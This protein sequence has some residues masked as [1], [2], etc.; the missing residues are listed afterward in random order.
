MARPATPDVKITEAL[1]P[2]ASPLGIYDK[3]AS[4]E[5]SPLHGVAT[6]L[7]SLSGDL[8][9]WGAKQ[10]AD[11]KAADIARGELNF[12]RDNAA[13]Y[14]EGVRRG[15]IPI[16][17]SPNVAEGYQRAA[18]L[19]AGVS[20]D[21]TLGNS[22][23]EWGDSTNPDP[24]A[25]ETWFRSNVGKNIPL[26]ASGGFARGLA[27]QLAQLHE[28][29]HNK[30]QAEVTKN[31]ENTALV[32]YGAAMA[33]TV[34]DAAQ[35]AAQDG[36]LIDTDRLGAN[37]AAIR[38]HGKSIGL[39]NAQ[40]D[41]LLL[42]TIQ[43][44]TLTTRDPSLLSLY[45]MPSAAGSKLSDT[46]DGVEAKKKTEDALT[47]LW[48]TQETEARQQQDR[49][50]KLQANQAQQQIIDQL[51]KDPNTPISDEQMAPALKLNG[52]F[53]IDVGEWQKKLREGKVVDDPTALSHLYGDILSGKANRDDIM[54]AWSAGQLQTPEA[55][56][57]AM[58]FLKT[59]QDYSKR[60]D[61]ILSQGT[62]KDTVEAIKK[63]G[64][65]PGM[66]DIFGNAALT[67]QGMQA[68]SDFR[69]G[70][71]KWDMQHPDADPIQRQQFLDTYG[72]KILQG[73]GSGG[74]GA[75]PGVSSYNRPAEAAAVN[76]AVNLM[77]HAQQQPQ[78]PQP[79]APPAPAQQP[80]AP[81]TPQ[82]PQPAAPPW[83][84][85]P[86]M[87]PAIEQKAK[88]LGVPA[89]TIIDSMNRKRQQLLA[90]P[91]AVP[92]TPPQVPEK[93]SDL[94][95]PGAFQMAAINPRAA[96]EAVRNVAQRLGL[97]GA[98]SNPE[99]QA[100]SQETSNAMNS[101]RVMEIKNSS[102]GPMLQQVAQQTGFDPDKLMAIA[103]I[104]SS[105]DHLAG[106]G[107]GKRPLT[108]YKGLFQL[109]ADEWRR[110]GDGGDI[111]DPEANARAA[112]R[113][114]Q[115]KSARFAKEFGREPSATELYMMHQQ[116][117]A[118][119]RSHEQRPDAPAWTNMLRT[120]E[121]RRKGEEWAKRAIWGNVPTDM[122]RHFG[123]VENITS[124]QFLAVW[125]SKLL[126]VGYEQALAM[127]GGGTANG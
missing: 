33:S 113:S 89:S 65:V 66:M 35:D 17:K 56:T 21:S 25:F 63:H 73:F 122:R 87:I 45:D 54:S 49:Q 47:H 46:P 36:T 86:E 75:A 4:P 101:Q 106:S 74:P 48:K 37:L 110:Y 80:A 32:N 55:M 116:G 9:A 124:R 60:P 117:E 120:G 97:G 64:A 43:A 78:A 94:G 96:V 22:F 126:G 111:Y 121:G 19:S 44:K 40:I 1:S 109:N 28:K 125:T 12:Y 27:P 103:S 77:P 71:I 23:S 42:A 7:S 6:A 82:A 99:P 5:P 98:I 8:A 76:D 67:P 20:L 91:P 3:P 84:P 108:P 118:G 104:E 81:Q 51:I 92:A 13:G 30:W 112:V 114:L 100:S 105:G 26:D 68:L 41:K 11:Q 102:V 62:A 90:N 57:K 24:Q 107:I 93:R 29:Y 39:Q 38:D 83:S 115:D 127:N 59:M 88:E 2:V 85:P 52:H 123:K 79:Q 50:D 70:A 95:S 15:E 61:N 34:D 69:V 119:L 58:G 31:V 53:K 72:A 18:G 16:D 10:Q 14:A